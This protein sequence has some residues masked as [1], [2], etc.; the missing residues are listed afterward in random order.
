MQTPTGTINVDATIYREWV[1]LASHTTVSGGD[2]Q[3]YLGW[4]LRLFVTRSGASGLY[5]ERGVILLRPDNRCFAVYGAIY[6]HYRALIDLENPAAGFNI[7]LPVGEE[8]AVANG[9]RS[10]F[11]AGDI[12]F[13]A[14]TG[15]SFEVHGAIR[16]HW[17]QLGG[18]NGFL[19]HP[20]SDES[21]VLRNGIEVGRFNLF[22]GGTIYWSGPTGAFEVHGA[23]RDMYI[24]GYGGPTGKLGFPLSDESDSPQGSKRYNTFQ[25]GCL[26]WDKASGRMMLFEALELF[27]DSISGS[28]SHT[29]FESIGV[30]SV[31][32]Y[33][34]VNM[35]TNTGFN[36]SQKLPP[37][38]DSYGQPNANP[39]NV[40]TIRPIRGDM[41]ISVSMDGWDHNVSTSDT[42]L[43]T[44]SAQFNA[45]NDFG[46]NQPRQ[47]NDG[48]F[49]ATFDLRAFSQDNPFDPNF[50]KD[51][52][53][54]VQNVGTPTLDTGQ[55]A[56]S[57]VDVGQDESPLHWFNSLFYTSVFRQIAAGGNCFGMSLES[58][59]AEKNCSL[60][61]EPIFGVSWNTARDEIN[62]K[63]GYQLGAEYLDWFVS[64]FVTGR[65]YNPI[66][67]Y[68]DSKAAFD[69]GDYPVICM[70]TTN[71]SE[72][73]CVRPCGPHAYQDTGS[74]LIITVAN[75]NTPGSDDSN[76]ENRIIID[77][78]ANTYYFDFNGNGLNPWTGG[79]FSGGIISWAPFCVLGHEPRTP[80]WEVLAAV[81]GIALIILGSDAQ[82]KQI[83]DD[84]GRTFYK[85]GLPGAPT[86]WDD[87]LLDGRQIP[88]LVRM[89]LN[90]RANGGGGGRIVPGIAAGNLPIAR[91]GSQ[92]A[93]SAFGGASLPELYHLSGL[94]SPYGPSPVLKTFASIKAGAVASVAS[95]PVASAQVAASNVS[96]SAARKI[97]LLGTPLAAG[98]AVRLTSGEPPLNLRHE[99]VGGSGAA[100]DWGV[101][102]A[103]GSLVAN[104]AGSKGAV[105]TMM[106]SG[107]GTPQQQIQISL[108]AKGPARAA[109]VTLVGPVAVDPK[110]VRTFQ[111]SQLN[112]QPGHQ[113]SA[114]I[115]PDGKSLNL[116]NVGPD[117]T[118]QLHA[119]VGFDNP[120]SVTKNGVLASG[121]AATIT[122]QDWTNLPNAPVAM[123][124][125]AQVGGAVE[126]TVNL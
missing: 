104:V 92:L 115:A 56:E 63:Q 107:F 22:E 85:P 20:L 58:I 76:P 119:Q 48:D 37:D 98:A 14:R 79:N 97:A 41:T 109:S 12:Y 24:H 50:R 90:H 111:L 3:S 9:R 26:T 33:A 62:E 67:V 5:F 4:P 69:R 46:L 61:S 86:R 65:F 53:W 118:F 70:T 112:L 68:Y 74:Q 82:T 38:R 87:M 17:E 105:D 60:F 23:I 25:N 13:D 57:F 72:G 21:P 81:L 45:D 106:V 73:H 1:S 102:T 11:D 103:A 42:H 31:W 88:G 122:P 59:Y 125:K 94:P 16:A 34:H 114:Q 6:V 84:Q 91:V 27:V 95:L 51:F 36:F 89:P 110:Q 40:T 77:K 15:N 71:L 108:D 54:G 117:V 75:P 121:K 29:F 83:T 113:F 39:G 123:A 93:A 43:G 7:G 30:S 66:C 49:H 44:V 10:R 120:A 8:E 32:I 126:K 101:R 55:F 19:G 78:H 52:M 2:V 124:V 96:S 64:N 47:L 35:T 100:Y 99:I 18:V 80:F 116:T 28:G